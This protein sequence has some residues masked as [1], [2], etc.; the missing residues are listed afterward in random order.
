MLFVLADPKRL[1]IPRFYSVP[2][3]DNDAGPNDPAGGAPLTPGERDELRDYLHDREQRRKSAKSTLLRFLAN[4]D[5]LAQL[6]L[7]QAVPVSFSLPDSPDYAEFLEVRTPEREGNL[8][9]ATHQLRYDDEDRLLAQD[10]VIVLLNGQQLAFKIN[11]AQST[12][13]VADAAPKAQ[14]NWRQWFDLAAW[15]R[16]PL[17]QP[18]FA[19]ALCALL[20]TGLA[21]LFFNQDST[22]KRE[23]VYTASPTPPASPT[24][25]ATPATQATVNATPRPTATPTL[26]PPASNEVA[27]SF[28]KARAG[29]ESDSLRRSERADAISSLATQKVFLDLGNDAFSNSLRPRLLERLSAGSSFT[30]TDSRDRDSVRLKVRAKSVA[31]NHLVLIAKILDAN[32]KVIWPLIPKVE[33]LKYKG[34]TDDTLD[35]FSGELVRDIRQLQQK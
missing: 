3:I 24:V 17:W 4:G 20:A 5:E 16:A 15:F 21:Y 7:Q 26:Q 27:R 14:T 30:L 32:G 11:A 33:A 29:D 31:P 13:T 8:L 35:R 18:A 22:P 34:P 12:I 10:A 19:L 2:R 28:I 6:D 23:I 25:T 9:L 1:D